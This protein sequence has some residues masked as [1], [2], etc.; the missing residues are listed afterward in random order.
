MLAPEVNADRRW[1]AWRAC[2]TRARSSAYLDRVVL[3]DDDA[4]RAQRH[5]RG[6]IA[7]LVG[8]GDPAIDGLCD[9][10]GHARPEVRAL[11]ARALAESTSPRARTCLGAGVL[12]P[13]AE[14]RA[15]V[16]G[17]LPISLVRGQVEPGPGWEMT[18]RLVDDP[19]PA[20]RPGAAELLYLF[21]AEA[22]RPAAER[23]AQDGDP[24]VGAAGQRAVGAVQN[25]HKHEKL[26]GL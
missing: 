22:A 13:R 5:L 12:H 14:V 7:L 1:R 26:L 25:A 9:D 2:T 15:A 3:A 8:L 19:D 11:A 21:N 10:L 6:A 4:L 17:A 24:A 16:G 20:V 18:N 23:L